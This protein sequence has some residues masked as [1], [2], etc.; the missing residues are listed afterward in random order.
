MSGGSESAM[1]PLA[2]DA[3]AREAFGTVLTDRQCGDCVACCV[4]LGIELPD[5]SKKPGIRCRHLAPAGGC[6]IYQT[7]PTVCRV[8]HCLW[9][10]R[11]ELLDD[12]RP[13]RCG[14]IFS[15]HSSKD[16]GPFK[17]SYFRAVCNTPNDFQHPA[18]VQTVA[19]LVHMEALPVWLCSDTSNVMFFPDPALADAILHPEAV[20][21]QALL[22]RAAGLRS[23]WK[24]D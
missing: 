16:A 8:W 15:V 23:K 9:R 2:I 20:H 14:V 7:R 22:T 10:V 3:A 12:A 24:L 4:R 21:D 11:I 13:D 19:M 5:E 18:V 17:D 1:D 6:S